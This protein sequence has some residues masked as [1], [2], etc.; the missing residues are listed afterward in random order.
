[1]FSAINKKILHAKVRYYLLRYGA[2][3]AFLTQALFLET[4]FAMNLKVLELRSTE[5]TPWALVRLSK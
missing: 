5:L 4:P 2:I 1:M 3:V